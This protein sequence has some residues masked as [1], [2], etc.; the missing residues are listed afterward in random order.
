MKKLFVLL[1]LALLV[2]LEGCSMESDNFSRNQTISEN[3]VYPI[4]C[5]VSDAHGT[6]MR[7]TIVT[8][9]YDSSRYSGGFGPGKNYR[10]MN[11]RTDENGNF[12]M[13]L[14]RSIPYNFVI[15]EP[16]FSP[17]QNP[18]SY[19]TVLFPS[20]NECIIKPDVSTSQ[21]AP[22]P[23]I[24]SN[25]EDYPSVE[26]LNKKAGDAA[27]WFANKIHDIFTRIF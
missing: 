22:V 17:L 18:Y 14:N 24:K 5:H 21:P 19:S 13:P 9:S 4:H 10:V 23:A 27:Y 15:S 8:I 11:T 1:L 7:Y 12:S 26:E 6:P 25:W 3:E 20:N 2:Y 16:G